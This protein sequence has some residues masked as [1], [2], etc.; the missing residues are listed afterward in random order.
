MVDGLL[1]KWLKIGVLDI[2]IDN[3]GK[4][5]VNWFFFC[6]CECFKFVVVVSFLGLCFVFLIYLNYCFFFKEFNWKFMEDLDVSLFDEFGGFVMIF[7]FDGL[8]NGE[9]I[10]DVLSV[11]LSL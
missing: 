11:I 8:I 4:Y 1:N 2:L 6:V 3:V 10:V 9:I 7:N 5:N